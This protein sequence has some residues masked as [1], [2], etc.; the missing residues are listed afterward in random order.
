MADMTGEFTT[1]QYKAHLAH[2]DEQIKIAGKKPMLIGVIPLYT[3]DMKQTKCHYGSIVIASFES[4]AA[5][6]KI[7]AP[8]TP[9][10]RPR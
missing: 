4:R 3:N 6:R 9:T 8:P 10:F 1:S 7:K 5:A 2:I